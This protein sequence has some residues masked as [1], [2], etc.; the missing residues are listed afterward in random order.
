M[1]LVGIL[2]LPTAAFATEEVVSCGHIFLEGNTTC[3]FRRDQDC[4]E[5]CE[6]VSVEESCAADLYTS[7]ETECTAT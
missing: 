3:E 6:V 2:S 7:C 4:T 1:P 5:T